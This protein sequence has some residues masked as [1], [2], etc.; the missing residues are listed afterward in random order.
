MKVKIAFNMDKTRAL[1][2]QNP[3]PAT[4]KCCRCKGQARLAFVAHEIGRAATKPAVCSLW[5]NQGKGGFW[6]HDHIA[7]AVYFCR[8]CLQPTAI[9]NQA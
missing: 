3:F 6:P 9:Y 2:F 7:V 4:T 5:P 8:E 1:S